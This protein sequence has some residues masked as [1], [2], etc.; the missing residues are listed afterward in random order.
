M[1]STMAGRSLRQN[2]VRTIVAVIGSPHLGQTGES[3]SS[4][5]GRLS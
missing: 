1:S 5:G 4:A 2:A 3:V